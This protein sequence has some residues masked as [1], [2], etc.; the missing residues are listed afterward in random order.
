M[1]KEGERN[2]KVEFILGRAGSGKTTACYEQIEEELK[3][4][5]YTDLVMLVPEQF[6]LQT[7]ISLSKR[8][9]PG[10][11]RVQVMSFNTLVREVFKE[12]GKAEIPIIDDLERI[13]ILKKIIEEHK[14]E[15][16]FFRKSISNIGFIEAINRLI[17]IFEQDAIDEKVLTD[18]ISDKSAT[19]LFRSK[20]Q[21]IGLIYRYFEEQIHGKFLTAEKTLKLLAQ[22]IC[23]SSKLSDITLWMDGFYGFTEVQVDIIKELIKKVKLLTITLPSDKIY[24]LGEG[25]RETNPFYESIKTF[26]K[27][28][29][30]CQENSIQYDT[31]YLDIKAVTHPKTAEEII[32]LEEN[33]LS[34]YAQPFKSCAEN[35]NLCIY[36][37]PND[38]VEQ[39]AK[40]ITELVRADKYRYHDIAVLVG[41]LCAYKSKLQSVFAEYDIPYFLDMK[42]NIHTN[43]LVAVIEGV[44][45]VI[46]SH[47][48]YKSVMTLLRTYMIH[49]NKED[50]DI[51]E[52]YI[53]AHGIK[54]KK[55][56]YQTWSY[57]EEDLSHEQ[58]IN[59]IKETILEP[60]KK[61]EERMREIKSGGQIKVVD[62]TR[63]I[64]YF[65]EDIHAYKQ[66]QSYVK[67]SR[68]ES[69]RILELENTQIWG[70]V[71]EAF[72]RLVS[73][74]GDEM[75]T[76]AAYKK[77][78][79]TS[80]S[81]LEM[82]IIPPSQDQV[83]IGTI[84]RTRLPR[85]RAV[86]ILGT[87][88]GMIPNIN[89]TVPLFSD[90]DKVTLNNLCQKEHRAKD[91][92]CDIIV[93][94]P[95]YASNFAIYT[96]LTR[97][98]D[99][100]YISAV[101]ADENGK[102]LRPSLV[103]YKLKK[104]FPNTPLKNGQGILDHVTR[105]LPT[106][107]Y[108]GRLLR[109]YIEDRVTEEE[110]KDIVSWYLE[111]DE[112][113]VRLR[114]LPAYLFYS[115][116]Q[117]YLEKETAKMLYLAPLHT[118]VSQLETF[119]NCAC[120]YF[121]RYGIRAEERK[122]FSLDYAAIGTLFH[123]ALEQYPKE[124]DA[125]G[126]TWTQ[127]SKEQIDLSVKGASEYAITTYHGTYKEVGKLKYTKI[128]LEKMTRRAVNAL[129]AHAKNSSFV[130]ERYEV[131]FA[132][133]KMLP[134]IHIQIDEGRLLVLTGQIDRVD[135][136]YKD[137]DSAYIK[138]LDYKTGNKYFNLL[139]VYYGLQLQL[140]LYLDA[141]LKLNGDYQPGG[142][143]YFHITSPYI[144]Y[145][146]G[147]TEDDIALSDLKQFKLSG[148]ALEEIEVIHALD[149][150]NT[151]YTVPVSLNKDGSIKK[152]SSVATKQQFES[153]EQHI[154]ETI[155]NLGR[156]ILEGKV[157]A[158][159]FKLGDKQPCMYCK[160][161]T[162]CQFDENQPDN[163]CERLEYLDKDE[164]WE[165]LESRK[166]KE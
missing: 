157:S 51:L 96:A 132:E 28:V 26:Q 156:Q 29:K 82:G 52:N 6:N 117:H 105:A 152:G 12:V 137:E 58:H 143:F 99:K 55:K 2:V 47:Y 111:N 133:G 135:V 140:L 141:Y 42:R 165:R 37:N 130:P 162:I 32:Y 44:L 14:D 79:S 108:I 146:A 160:Y 103:Y 85:L 129:T 87:N 115:N 80:F 23:K 18:F 128:Q 86:F 139:E 113:K 49:A 46:I 3:Y 59:R 66:L 57:S 98:A 13:M 24:G 17:T 90:M 84:D 67:Q 75:T 41:D 127:A 78:I 159:P 154:I 40:Y 45:D 158:K 161:H 92:F 53:L 138:I 126:T 116:Q 125:L 106:F 15:L 110:W 121:I 144:Q 9:Y 31:K 164:I 95:I 89:D 1:R 20:L 134:P 56:W 39:A 100:L 10:L 136:Y 148:I 74:L 124:L 33:Y 71:A 4:D 36:P 69:N 149:K 150:N 142:V 102:A 166:E 16:V 63:C 122:I 21:D 62:L 104:M 119:R 97:A 34:H 65:L 109:E 145:Q 118:N 123:A 27:L 7:Q 60:I 35:I 88:E 73:I 81:Y 70:Q 25:V 43:I 76:V 61:L 50:I 93:H 83:L 114:G 54:G 101:S 19:P 68:K 155:K 30:A 64:Y 151:G 147:M 163:L 94:Q 91:K 8:L 153:L 11:F 112:W 107:G 72:E 38:E 131:S 48:S 22:S 5:H 77:I 120:C